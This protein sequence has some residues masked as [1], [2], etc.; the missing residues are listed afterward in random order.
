MKHEPRFSLDCS[1]KKLKMKGRDDSEHFSQ[2]TYL[3][4]LIKLKLIVQTHR[5]LER[6]NFSKKLSEVTLKLTLTLTR[7]L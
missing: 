1:S 2:W 4:A 3:L 6:L 5:S 7:I